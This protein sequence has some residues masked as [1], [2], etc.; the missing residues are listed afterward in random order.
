MDPWSADRLAADAKGI[1]ASRRT[2]IP[3]LFA[4]WFARRLE[5]GYVEF[6][7]AGPPRRLR[8]SLLPRDVTH[9]N[10]WSKWPRPLFESLQRLQQVGYPTLWNV[11]ITGLGSS[12][13]EPHVPSADRA[14]DAVVEL[15]GRVPPA[16]ILWRYDPLFLSRRF[17]R[18]HHRTTF[19]RLA[20]QLQGKVDRVVISPLHHYRRQV[21]PDLGAYQR[22]TGDLVLDDPAATVEL[23]RELATIAGE[24]RLPLTVC[25]APELRAALGVE[26]AACNGFAWA[27]RV[28]PE[29]ARHPGL[30]NRPCRP[31]CG[32]SE[33]VDIGVYDTCVL[34]CRYSYGSCNL[35]RARE[36]FAR[37][38]PAAA[39]ILPAK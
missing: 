15:A 19:R 11:T 29:L 32:C 30:K 34:G 12:A 14:A 10:F 20:R 1:S 21:V 7:P 13:V 35:E 18:R 36:N 8:R 4:R 39:A 22:E 9:F 16:A 5:A 33:E 17:D 31:D 37:H 24:H 38:D 2:D 25:C 6:I 26:R 28:Y 27:R 23:A 3:G